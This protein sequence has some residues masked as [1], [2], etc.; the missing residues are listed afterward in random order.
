MSEELDVLAELWKE[1]DELRDKPDVAEVGPVG[2]GPLVFRVNITMIDGSK[3]TC[4]VRAENPWSAWI[5]AT[6]AV[7]IVEGEA[8]EVFTD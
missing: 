7:L 4:R 1:L 6:Q 2:T 3:H 8:I 5:Y